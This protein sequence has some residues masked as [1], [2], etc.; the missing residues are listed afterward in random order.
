MLLSLTRPLPLLVCTPPCLRCHLSLVRSSGALLRLPFV[1]RRLDHVLRDGGLSTRLLGRCQD[2]THTLVS[3][4]PCAGATSGVSA[5]PQP[6]HASAHVAV[7]VVLDALLGGAEVLHNLHTVCER[8]PKGNGAAAIRSGRR[9]RRTRLVHGVHRGR[10]L[11]QEPA[12]AQ[13]LSTQR[14]QRMQQDA[15]LTSTRGAARAPCA[16]PCAR[17]RRRPAGK[18]TWRLES[19]GE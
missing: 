12:R 4:I 5:V 6:A 7:H 9:E 1:L 18:S 14:R 15:A 13:Q 10:L 3:V 16:A 11:G 2:E 19:G 17:A 8:A